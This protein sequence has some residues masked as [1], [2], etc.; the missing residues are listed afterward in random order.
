[1]RNEVT[2]LSEK[3]EKNPHE[4]HRSR[5]KE[6]FLKEGLAHFSGHEVLEMLLYYAIP[7]RDT[8]DLGH[9]IEDSF[10]SLTKVLEADYHDLVKVDGVTPHIATLITLC[11]QLARRYQRE[12]YAFVAPLY[13]T[14][15]FGK[16]LLPWFSGQKDESVVLMSMD[17]RYKVLNTTRVFTGSV[18]STQFS[19]RGAVQ[20]LL[21]DN[22]TMVVMAHNHPN[23][24]ALPSNADIETTRRFAKILQELGIKL[25]DHLIVSD[26]DF[27]SL[28]QTRETA[29]IFR[30]GAQSVGV[31]VA[32]VADK[33]R[34]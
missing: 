16:H 1:M 28:A 12:Q 21:R 30:A 2:A 13:H 27:I 32:R 11:G 14:A 22:A 17:N 25:I 26:D 7:Y 19:M 4:G 6:R 10:G 5:M 24:H 29:E 20:Q 8:N 34:K 15:D 31:S 3:K 23:G 18:N 33:S 9:K